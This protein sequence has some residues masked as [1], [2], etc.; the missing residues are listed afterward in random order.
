MGGRG[1]FA[2]FRVQ[3][4]ILV[5]GKFWSAW[6]K[7]YSVDLLGACSSRVAVF[8]FASQFGGFRRSTVPASV[9]PSGEN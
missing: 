6:R 3:T 1:F 4:M 8:V 7:Y 5:V 2:R 9:L